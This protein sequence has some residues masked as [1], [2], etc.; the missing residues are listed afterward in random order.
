MADIEAAEKD[1]MREKCEKIV[2]HGINC[3]VNRQVGPCACCPGVAMHLLPIEL[4]SWFV[5]EDCGAR[6]QLL[7]HD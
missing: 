2:G 1:K 4:E 7:C 6:H 5:Q 3:F